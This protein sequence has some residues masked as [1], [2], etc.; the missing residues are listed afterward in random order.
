M[1]VAE[2]KTSRRLSK[3]TRVTHA[4]WTCLVDY[5][6]EASSAWKQ[7]AVAVYKCKQEGKDCPRS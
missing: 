2:D 3:K 1:V 4:C 5:P 6:Q 7:K